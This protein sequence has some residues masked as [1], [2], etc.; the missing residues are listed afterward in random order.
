MRIVAQVLP[1]SDPSRVLAELLP[2]GL[3]HGVAAT[4]VEFP[5][6]GAVSPLDHPAYQLLEQAVREAHPG[7]P[8]GPYFLP[9]A[10][11]DARFFRAA[12]L[13]SYGFSPFLLPV[14]DTMRI[15]MA[16]ERL[17]LP[18]YVD[19]VALYRETVRRLLDDTSRPWR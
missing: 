5:T 13:P 10:A 8:V 9:W 19:G 15:G 4:E 14:T 16:N 2:E 3:L 1:A 12:G 17:S 18:G 7:A 6:P 11:T